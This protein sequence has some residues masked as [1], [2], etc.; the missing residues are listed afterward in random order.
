MKDENE[1]EVFVRS[2]LEEGAEVDAARLRAL[3]RLAALTAASRRRRAPWRWGVPLVAAASLAL[4]VAFAVV[5]TGGS[6]RG[7]NAVSDAIGLLCE[8]DG[9]PSGEIA[10]DSAGELLLAWQEAPCA[11]LL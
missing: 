9:I 6:L 10:A 4:A 3:E 2:A 7:G 8:L 1:F 11:D 5:F